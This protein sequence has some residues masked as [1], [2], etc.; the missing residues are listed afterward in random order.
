MLQTVLT[1]F[2]YASFGQTN[3]KTKRQDKEPVKGLPQ[4]GQILLEGI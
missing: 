2:K 4:L 1:C 3:T